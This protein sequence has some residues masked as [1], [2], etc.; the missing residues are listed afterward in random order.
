MALPPSPEMRRTGVHLVVPA[1]QRT[2]D[3]I[4]SLKAANTLASDDAGAAVAAAEAAAE[5]VAA[6]KERVAKQAAEQ[7]QAAEAVEEVKEAVKCT[8]VHQCI[9]L[10][11]VPGTVAHLGTSATVQSR[12][13]IDPHT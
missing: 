10:L 4:D 13:R 9:S 12:L 8:W 2:M 3:T 1:G 6:E 7:Q 5:E 11:Y